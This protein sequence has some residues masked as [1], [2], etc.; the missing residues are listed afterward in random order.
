MKNIFSLEGKV[1]LVT[2]ASRGIGR[3]VAISCAKSGANIALCGRNEEGLKSVK[4][5]I[6]K[7][8]VNS[9]YVIADMSNVEQIRKM[10]K[11]TI[12]YFGKIDVLI[13][14]AAICIRENVVD[15][16]E[17]S[18][19]NQI[20][21]NLRGVFF[22]AQ[23]MCKYLI[24][25]KR[26]GKIIN[27]SSEVGIIGVGTYAVYS[28]TKGGV[29]A[30]TRSLAAEMGKFN[31]QVNAVCPGSTATEMN[32]KGKTKEREKEELSRIVFGRIAKPVEIAAGVIYLASDYSEMITGQV[33][34]IDGGSTSTRAK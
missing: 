31:I 16:T 27:I 13:N 26:K 2:G 33:L 21:I 11:D 19:D 18:F 8:G 7:V 9:E 1:I 3:E 28:A 5:E 34:S 4:K 17:E 15:V 22:A 24:E 30:M 23:A 32:L 10:V 6:D 29:I 20:S 14:N 12:N 25:N